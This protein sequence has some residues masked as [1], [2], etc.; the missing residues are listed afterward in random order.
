MS[1]S[2]RRCL[3][4]ANVFCYI[5]G[6]VTL[7]HNR[8]MINDHLKKLYLAYFGVHLG[9]QDKSW[10]P[11]IACHTCREHLR[12]WSQGTRKGL[13]FG[14]PM[15]WREPTNHLDNCYFCLPN[16]KGFG[17]KNKKHIRY[18]DLEFARRPVSH[19]AELH[20][21]ISIE[22]PELPS[23]STTIFLKTTPQLVTPL[24]RIL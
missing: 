22:L 23:N 6:E 14:I 21:P 11:H 24:T 5:C 1:S 12:Q 3:N 17:N 20:V 8:R 18:H 9:D 10:A 19:S 2:N 13:S 16:I 4:D 7:T 15:V